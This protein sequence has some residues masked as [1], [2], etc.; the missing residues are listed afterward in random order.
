VVCGP[1]PAPT[2]N[3]KEKIK[4]RMMH[5]LTHRNLLKQQSSSH[6]ILYRELNNQKKAYAGNGVLGIVREDF[7]IWERRSPLCPHHV[8][9]L[10]KQGLVNVV[11]AIFLVIYR[12]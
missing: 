4:S 6:R 8:T 9:D 7:S 5:R 3:N 10:T 1:T 11:I 12:L 2:T